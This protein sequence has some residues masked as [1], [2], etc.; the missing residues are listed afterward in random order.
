M[1][2]CPTCGEYP[3]TYECDRPEF[4]EYL[5]SL[6]AE[7]HEFIERVIGKDLSPETARHRCRYLLSESHPKLQAQAI[8][9]AKAC[10]YDFLLGMFEY[11]SFLRVAFDRENPY[12]AH[13]L[14]GPVDWV[15]A[16][17]EPEPLAPGETFQQID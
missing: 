1:E 2:P 12:A 7:P 3:C 5:S 4:V 6:P 9:Q 16:N 17:F 8:L 13:G 15:N 14:S 11:P 10:R